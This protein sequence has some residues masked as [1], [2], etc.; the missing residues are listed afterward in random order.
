MND[1]NEE[2]D[3][4][5]DKDEED[6][7]IFQQAIF[8]S[9][10]VG[11]YVVNHLCKEP[12]RTS[13]LKGHSWVQ[14]I[15]QGNPT[16]CYEMFRMEKHVFNLLCIELVELGLKSSNRM[17]V[18]EMVA[19]F[20][21]VVGHGVGNRMIQERFQ[22][23]GETV[24]RYFHRV[25]HVV[26]KLSIKYIKPEDPMFRDCHS[27][28]KNDQRYWPF[29]KNAIGAIDGT[30]VSCVVSGSEQ[31][32]F[33]GRKGYPTQNIMAV[34]DWNMCFT[35]VL[36]GWEGIVHDARVFDQ[37]LTNANLNFPH[38]PPGLL[39]YTTTNGLLY[40]T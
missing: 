27:K 25:L 24:S 32:R 7:D 30:H 21:V 31:T 33:I 39:F 20:L 38:P 26:L 34:C 18:E 23:S 8:V 35:F 3:H 12:C 40:L 37:A 16:R 1:W 19:M 10:L 9:A 15:L 28:I 13:E 29:F 11:E 5:R 17:T 36:A 6:D 22:H 14:E 4:T 2:S